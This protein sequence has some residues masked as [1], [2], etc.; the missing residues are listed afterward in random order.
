MYNTFNMGIGMAVITGREDADR[1]V[2]ILRENGIDAV[3][4]GTVEEGDH[5]VIFDGE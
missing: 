5:S 1:A 4:I 3:R 2:R